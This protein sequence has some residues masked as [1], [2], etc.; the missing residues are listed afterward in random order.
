MNFKT[1]IMLVLLLAIVAIYFFFVARPAP[2]TYELEQQQAQSRSAQGQPLFTADQI[3]TEKVTRLTLHRDGL[4]LTFT[5]DADQ[6]LQTQPVRFPLSNWPIRQLIDD[7]AGLRYIDR[8]SPGQPDKP[9]LHDASLAT[10]LATFT[11]QSPD[12]AHTI[13]LGKRSLAGRAYVMIDDQPDIFVVT[14]ALHRALLDAKP[15]DWRQKTLNP[16]ATSAT[17]AITLQ[18]PQQS[19]NLTKTDGRW[20][21]D[22]Q[23]T[24]RASADK[25]DQLVTAVRRINIDAF[26]TDAPDDLSIF[27][28]DSP[29]IHLTITAPPATPATEPDGEIAASAPATDEN[30]SPAATPQPRAFHLR[31]GAPADLNEQTCF[32]TWSTD[33][34]PS[35]VVFTI[36]KTSLEGLDLSPDD[37]RDSRLVTASASD[38][39]EIIIDRPDASPIHLLHDADGTYSFADPK[40]DYALDYAAASSLLDS[41]VSAKADSFAAP[42]TSATPIATI[43]LNLRDTNASE[44]VRLYASDTEDHFHAVRNGETIAYRLPA[45]TVSPLLPPLLSL[46]DRQIL[47]LPADQIAALTLTRDDGAVFEFVRAP[48]TTQSSDAATTQPAPQPAS[49]PAWQLRGHD[50]YESAS[51]EKLLASLAPLRAQSW[52]PADA[53]TDPMNIEFT[54][55]PVIGPPL[56]LRCDPQSRQATLTGIDATFILPQSFVDQLTAEYRPRTVLALNRDSIQSIAI[57]SRDA[58][59]NLHNADDNQYVDD[60]NQPVDQS[61]AA[62]LFD[63]LSALRVDRFLT[64]APPTSAAEPITFTIH[65][66]QGQ[67][68]E[69]LLDRSTDHAS[70]PHTGQW[71]TLSQATREKLLA[72]LAQEKN[73]LND[74][75]DDGPLM[76]K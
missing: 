14:D 65:P 40:P 58:T 64:A 41:L 19:I 10:P 37:L 33:D 26:I 36:Q 60:A 63:A 31:V 39:R 27:G 25:V 15:S 70:L 11:L 43:T 23:D 5:K 73:A 59:I 72:P 69:L 17:D 29:Q 30:A 2:T 57:V 75:D 38:V 34:T 45:A 53:P 35:P 3:A 21:L 44:T 62:G 32:A 50:A 22:A 67:P 51:F 47:N 46:R 18:Q 66:T 7:A 49:P 71:F 28:L 42:P 56:Q 6:W 1:T 61:A 52:L 9:T 74:E 24:Q 54:I 4:E 12:S 48:A 13:R 76:M 8:F 16:P 68:I 20:F 55:Q